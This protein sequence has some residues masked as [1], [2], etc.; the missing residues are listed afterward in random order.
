MSTSIGEKIC[1]EQGLRKTKTRLLL[2]EVL[3]ESKQPLAIPDILEVFSKRGHEINKTTLY[4]EVE[5][6]VSQEVLRSVQIATRKISY[7]LASHGHHHHFVCTSCDYVMDVVFPETAIEKTEQI[8]AREGVIVERH[9]LEFFGLC[10]M[11][12]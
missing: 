5:S 3:A 8:L 2:F 10:K 7:E 4:R 12:N 6:L 11:C 9:S 1:E